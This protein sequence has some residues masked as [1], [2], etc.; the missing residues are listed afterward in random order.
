[1][2]WESARIME[3]EPIAIYKM[4]CITIKC[5]QADGWYY[6]QTHNSRQRLRVGSTRNKDEA[7][8][9]IKRIL[10]NGFVRVK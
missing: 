6:I 4:N 7:N 8:N 9:Y 2:I 5:F 3:L 10:K 1:M